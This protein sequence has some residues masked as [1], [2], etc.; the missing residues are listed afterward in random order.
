VASEGP[1]QARDFGVVRSS[2][3]PVTAP[4]A[5]TIVATVDTLASVRYALTSP[6]L[7]GE[8]WPPGQSVLSEA[9]LLSAST[10]V[11]APTANPVT[12]TPSAPIAKPVR[13][14]DDFGVSDDSDGTGAADDSAGGASGAGWATGTIESERV[15][16]VPSSAARIR[17]SGMN[18]GAAAFTL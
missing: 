2:V 13:R 9:C 4:A 6:L 11:T 14:D 16:V 3:I 12:P 18:P 17:S 10:P 15:C 7:S 8:Q 5:P 1:L